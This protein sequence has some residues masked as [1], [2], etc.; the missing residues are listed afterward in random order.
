M[1]R[2]S[3]WMT[4]L[5]CSILHS[6][7]PWYLNKDLWMVAVAIVLPFGWVVPAYR[8]ARV[9]AHSRRTRRF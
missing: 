2:I 9:Y 5:K 3:E 6:N 7:E 8:Y 4:E 1:N